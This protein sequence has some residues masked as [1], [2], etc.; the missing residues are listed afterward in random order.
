MIL[1]TRMSIIADE[2]NTLFYQSYVIR[3]LQTQ[4]KFRFALVPKLKFLFL[5]PD[6]TNLSFPY[7]E[8]I[9]GL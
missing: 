1:L 6:C 2:Q 7:I 3:G 8:I 4:N 9:F 5:H